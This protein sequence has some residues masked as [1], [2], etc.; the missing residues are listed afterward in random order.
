ML[1]QYRAIVNQRD[2][3]SGGYTLWP[4]GGKRHQLARPPNDPLMLAAHGGYENVVKTLLDAGAD[5]TLQDADGRTAADIAR[6]RNYMEVADMLIAAT[7]PS[8]E[9][10]PVTCLKNHL[11]TTIDQLLKQGIEQDDPKKIRAWLD[12]GG[13]VE[14]RI[15]RVSHHCFGQSLPVEIVLPHC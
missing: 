10:P 12:F 7:R 6:S 5:P 14:Q 8:I 11:N 4:R 15:L 3:V 13:P 9:R 1:V 2:A